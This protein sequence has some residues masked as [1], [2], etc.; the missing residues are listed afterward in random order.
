MENGHG[1]EHALTSGRTWSGGT[2]GPVAG[3][4]VVKDGVEDDRGAYL[5]RGGFASGKKDMFGPSALEKM[6][7]PPSPPQQAVAVA[8]NAPNQPISRKS[9]H[10]YA[11]I[12]PSRFEQV[13]HSIHGICLNVNVDDAGAAGG[14]ISVCG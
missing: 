3:T 1:S 6:F 12:N 14:P 10:A 2:G 4:F 8:S 7:Q 11:P 5:A 9:S 13:C